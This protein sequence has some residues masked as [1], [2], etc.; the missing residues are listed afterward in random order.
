MTLLQIRRS[1]ADGAAADAGLPPL[2]LDSARPVIRRIAETWGCELLPSQEMLFPPFQ[3]KPGLLVLPEVIFRKQ[4]ILVASNPAAN[5]PE[6]TAPG[7]LTVE[8]D[9]DATT[10]EDFLL[11][12]L[13]HTLA[14]ELGAE[15]FYEDDTEPMPVEPQRFETFEHYVDKV[16]EF[17][18]DLVKEMKRV[19]IYAHRKRAVR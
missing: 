17:E 11:M 5:T 8:R 12:K 16:L 18:E 1:A 4:G 3:G 10:W 9:E 13:A 7:A 2:S 15:L 6:R 19:W 14:Y